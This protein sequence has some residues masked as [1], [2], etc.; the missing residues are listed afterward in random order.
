MKNAKARVVRLPVARMPSQERSRK[1]FNALLDATRDLL[2]ERDFSEIGIYDIAK[3]AKVRP[4]SAYHFLPT[5]ESAFLALGRRYLAEQSAYIN[6]PFDRS[7]IHNWPDLVDLRFH[8]AVAYLNE[9]PAYRRLFLSGNSAAIR[10]LDDENVDRVSSDSFAWMN[11]YVEM[12]Y[13]PSHRQKY[14]VLISIWDGIF[15]T[16]YSRHGSITDELASEA[17]IA[18]LAYCRTFLPEVLPLRPPPPP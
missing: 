12:P 2:I 4:T 5:T 18:G 1:R 6:R 9:N 8:R 15:M 11:E 10:R 14:I 7:T 16:S 17:R 3:R 13:L